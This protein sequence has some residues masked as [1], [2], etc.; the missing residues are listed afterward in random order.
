M[1][2]DKVR[3]DKWLWAARF[4]KTRALATDAVNGGK[5]HLNGQRIKPSRNVKLNDIYDVQR[6]FERYQIVVEK[7]SDRRGSASIAKTLYYETE[8]SIKKRA[9]EAQ[10]RKL[11]NMQRPT[12]DH[13]PNKKERRKI[14]DLTGKG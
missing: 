8:A 6:G 5:V 14:R 4:Y 1:A 7:L 11:A 9:K 2:D 13:K 12:F 10:Q 3:I